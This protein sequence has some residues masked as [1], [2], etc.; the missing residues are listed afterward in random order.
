MKK[1]FIAGAT[2]CVLAVAV[3]T[4]GAQTTPPAGEPTRSWLPLTSY[5]Y[6]GLNGGVTDFDTT[7]VPGFECDKSNVGF[8]AYAGGQLWRFIGLELGYVNVG[9]VEVGGG[10]GK[11]QGAN[12]SLLANLP[13]GPINAFAK[14]GT[15]YG[16]T[17][18]TTGVAGA[19]SG[20]DRGFGMSYGAGVGYD[21]A[22]NWQVRAEWDRYRFDFKGNDNDVDMFSLGAVYKF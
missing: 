9:K 2:G 3:G 5:G 18:T 7:C 1:L 12:L 4:A 20:R 8:K 21:L 11:A 10:S 19:P 13:I 15:T 22:R 6:V 14:V 16:F 17:K